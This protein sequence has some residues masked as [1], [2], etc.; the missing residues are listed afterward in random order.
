MHA[1]IQVILGSMELQLKILLLRSSL[2]LQHRSCPVKCPSQPAVKQ[3]SHSIYKKEGTRR[4]LEN[5][6]ACNFLRFA[7]FHLQLPRHGTLP[8]GRQAYLQV[9]DAY[10]SQILPIAIAVN[11]IL[12]L[13]SCSVRLQQ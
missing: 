4:P 9:Q 13:A 6:K 10:R 11:G 2:D 3:L 8:H 12:G 1:I 5:I 7:H